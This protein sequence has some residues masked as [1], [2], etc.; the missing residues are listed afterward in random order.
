MSRERKR[1]VELAAGGVLRRV[2]KMPSERN[3]RVFHF[4]RARYTLSVLLTFSPLCAVCCLA[5]FGIYGGQET[6]F[7]KLYLLK[8][9]NMFFT[10]LGNTFP[11]ARRQTSLF[12]LGNPVAA[13][14]ASLLRGRGCHAG[15]S[16]S[17]GS[18]LDWGE[19]LHASAPVGGESEVSSSLVVR[20]TAS[21]SRRLN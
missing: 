3:R 1:T 8:K 4:S 5:S 10:L 19:R 17:R 11:F 16:P 7:F 6:S 14:R 20:R 18:N 9:R 21:H 12:L 13:A 2:A 15:P